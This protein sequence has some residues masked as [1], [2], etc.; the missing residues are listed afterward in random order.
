MRNNDVGRG[1]A[2]WLKSTTSREHP[3]LKGE[4]EENFTSGGKKKSR[5]GEPR[6]FSVSQGDSVKG[7]SE[8]NEIKTEKCRICY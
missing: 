4:L 5:M 3:A 6:E 7:N 8:F 2:S 1:E